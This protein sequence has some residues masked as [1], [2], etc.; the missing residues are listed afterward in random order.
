MCQGVQHGWSSP[1]PNV[2]CSLFIFLH[3]EACE[4]FANHVV[5][6]RQCS[7]YYP[8][9]SCTN[10]SP[11]LA[12]YLL[13]RNINRLHGAAPSYSV[14]CL[15]HHIWWMLCEYHYWANQR[16]IFKHGDI[17]SWNVFLCCTKNS[18]F[19]GEL[20]FYVTNHN[21]T[22]SCISVNFVSL[23]SIASTSWL[24]GTVLALKNLER[25]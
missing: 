7:W 23:N 17:A 11:T 5:I 15:L 22:S 25:R 20:T 18:F 12:T 3:H 9:C 13:A 16:D 4:T 10:Y 24:D 21:I 1:T 2:C 8:Q 14:G 6:K 19:V